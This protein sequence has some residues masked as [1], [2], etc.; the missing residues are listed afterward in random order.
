MKLIAGVVIA[1]SLMMNVFLAQRL[2]NVPPKTEMRQSSDNMIVMQT[3]GGLLEVS[4]ITSEERFD[5][6]T[7]HTVLGVPIGTTVAQIRVPAVYRYHIP[8]AKEWTLRS[9]GEALLVI[10]PPVQPSLP[11]AINT[12]KLE[13]F[14]SGLWSP[15]TGTQS[16]ST[17]QKTI[18]QSLEK[19]ATTND[20][21]LLQRESARKTVTEFIQKWV[22]AQQRWK[23]TKAPVVLVFFSDEPLGA[24]T[25]PLLS[26]SP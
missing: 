25:T 5:S 14:K 2:W 9:T 22:V 6:A 21:L 18:T 16:I 13:G 10:A 7:N 24:K 17:L 11:V 15:I 8:L 20:L 1:V 12:A 26:P 19:K 3:P 4:T 23:G